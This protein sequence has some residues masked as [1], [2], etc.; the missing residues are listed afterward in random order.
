MN[1][2]PNSIAFQGEFGA[3]GDAVAR[4]LFPNSST[5][6]CTTF[7]EVFSAVENGGA[8]RA[9]IPID[10]SIAGRV[11]D[12]HP[13]LPHT[14]TYIIG[15][16]F[17]PIEHVLLGVPGATLETVRTARSHVHALAQCRMFLSRQGYVAEVAQ[18]TA[19]AAREVAEMQDPAVAAIAPAAA[20][21]LYGLETL[22]TDIADLPGNT[23]RFLVIS[24]EET[25]P[26]YSADKSF[27]TSIFFRL[28]SIPA[29]LHGAIGGFSE[30][31]INM[32]KIES[33]LDADF[34]SAHFYIEIEAHAQE[35][36]V[37]QAVDVLRA[38]STEVRIL[39]TYPASP[40]RKKS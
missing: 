39:G 37:K 15:E 28:Q 13:L 23:T 19:G 29:A 33:Y 26:T 40:F 3:N 38:H 2:A 10:N 1:P 34:Q 9:V 12:I 20:G 35:P 6:P 5:L 18:D 36:E 25:I 31:G 21:V 32:L 27:I 16:Y 11:A 17:Q 4:T 8:A 22:A 7:A 30:R 24:C 14:T